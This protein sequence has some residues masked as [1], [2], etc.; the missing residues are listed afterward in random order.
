[1]NNAAGAAQAFYVPRVAVAVNPTTL[2]AYGTGSVTTSPAQGTAANGVPPYS[3]QWSLTSGS[4][5]TANTPTQAATTF[6]GNA[7][8]AGNYA[9]FRLTVTD[10]SGGQASADVSV[11]VSRNGGGNQ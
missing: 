4:G 10:A 5:I 11:A 9:A 2:A 8:V 6:T 1:M 3:Y 7:T